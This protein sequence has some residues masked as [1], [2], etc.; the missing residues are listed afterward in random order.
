LIEGPGAFDGPRAPD[1][2]ELA[3]TLDLI[4]LVLRTQ[5]G[6]EPTFGWDFSHIYHE[7]NLDNVRI[8]CHGGHPVSSVGIHTTTVRTPLGTIE[9]G[10]I[11]GVVTH[12]DFRRLGLNT[13]TLRDAHARM[14]ATGR[15]IGLLTTDIPDYYR[16]LG[17]ERAGRQRSFV[18]DRHNVGYLPAATD[19][20]ITE[21]WRAFAGDLRAIHDGEP[22]AAARTPQL[23]DLLASRKAERIFVARRRT[24]VVAYAAAKG[25][26]VREYGGAAGDVAALLRL[27]F[28]VIEDQSARSTDRQAPRSEM[29]LLTPD[30][31]TGLPD[32]LLGLGIPSALE[33]LGMILILD[34]AGLFAALAI[35]AHVERRGERWRLRDQRGTTDL[36][37]GELT[38]LVFGPERRPERPSEHFPIEFFQWPMDRV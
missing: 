35:D 16:R 14:R 6:L 22:L 3:P 7:D 1:P 38:K 2:N 28:P 24:T 26:V 13:A 18:F 5:R 10:G 23:F 4:N 34:P 17:W 8:L 37:D 29:T 11:N 25:S 36:T 31:P 33:Y 9:V 27:M 20:D 19:L 15:H 30:S 21:D 32:R 12:P